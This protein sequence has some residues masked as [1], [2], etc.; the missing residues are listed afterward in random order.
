VA[1]ES[2]QKLATRQEWIGA[3]LVHSQ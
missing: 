3:V 1:A 2:R